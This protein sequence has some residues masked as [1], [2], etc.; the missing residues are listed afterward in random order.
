[1]NIFSK[2]FWIPKVHEPTETIDKGN[3]SSYNYGVVGAVGYGGNYWPVVS[4]SWD[5]EKTPGELGLVI[6]NIP[7]YKSLRLRAYDAYTKTDVIKTLA[8]R[9]FQWVI[10]SGLKLESEP[11]KMLLELEKITIPDSFKKS[12]EARW[13]VFTNSFYCDFERRRNLHSLALDV[14]SDKFKGGD[15]LV[16]CRVDEFGVNA[17]FVSGEHVCTPVMGDVL[18]QKGEGNYIEHGIEFNERG[19]HVAYYV[20]KK[21]SEN[22]IDNYERIPAYGGA[23]GRRLAWMIYGQ[24]LNPDQK[25]GVPEFAQILEKVAKLD[26]YTEASVSKAEQAAKILFTIEHQDFSTGENPLGDFI[27]NKTNSTDVVDPFVLA[28][29]LANKIAQ[30][31]S[32]TTIN[33]VRGSKLQSFGTD[34]EKNYAEFYNSNFNQISASIDTPPEVALQMYNSNYSASRA[35]INGWGYVV[36]I[37]RRNFS[38]Q[39][40]KPFYKLWLEIEILK[41]KIEAPGFILALKRNDFMIIEAYTQCRFTGRNMPHI[42]P[43]KEVKA[44]RAMLGEGDE[45]PLITHDQASE[46]LN[47]GDWSENYL[48]NEEERK[49]I[50]IKPQENGNTESQNGQQPTGLDS[51][52]T[53]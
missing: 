43:L 40:Y 6:R 41:N 15:C 24:K 5:G 2:E 10:G 23:T 11:N 17:Q 20:L 19:E 33:M 35:A 47:V 34:A 36:D 46:S 4:K 52:K 50:T 49:I 13:T 8:S 3:I 29:G 26:R 45:T 1:M 21:N 7:N 28:D 18:N 42:D 39:F 27:K 22:L 51:Q 14:Y 30:T 31:T 32:N 38:D 48:K 9:R 44:I 16:I 37:D 12:V 53:V 25:R